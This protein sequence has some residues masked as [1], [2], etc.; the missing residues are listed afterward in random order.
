MIAFRLSDAGRALRVA[1]APSMEYLQF[2]DVD[3]A[4]DTSLGWILNAN[5]ERPGV[6]AV[7]VLMN[8]GM[9]HATFDVPRPAGVWGQV[10]DGSSVIP[11]GI[12]GAAKVIGGRN[13]SLAVQPQTALIYRS[14]F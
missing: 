12:P 13:H 7:L 8:A 10:G 4:S 3:G 5:N 2:I 1:D 6:P 9:V 11:G 14:G